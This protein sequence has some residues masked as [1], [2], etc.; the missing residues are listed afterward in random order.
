MELPTT[1]GTNGL[2]MS[3]YILA[4]VILLLD[5]Q[6]NVAGNQQIRTARQYTGKQP[7]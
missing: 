6:Q 7:S 4:D 3:G 5:P 2:N 1:A